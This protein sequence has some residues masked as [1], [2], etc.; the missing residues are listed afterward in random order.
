VWSI[1]DAQAA[2][3]RLAKASSP[4]AW[5][6]S[7]RA[8][9]R[10]RGSAG[11]VQRVQTLAGTLVRQLPEPRYPR[12]SALLVEAYRLVEQDPALAWEVAEN[13]LGIYVVERASYSS[14]EN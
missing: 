1:V 4:P 10:E 14:S 7:A 13:L 8:V 9:A 3:A 2:D 6:A 5:V 11:N 12:A